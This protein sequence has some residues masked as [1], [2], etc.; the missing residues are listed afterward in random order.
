[1]S[2]CEK[3]LIRTRDSCDYRF[4]LLVIIL[5]CNVLK[6]SCEVKH[7]FSPYRTNVTMRCEKTNCGDR[8]TWQR[9]ESEVWKYRW[10]VWSVWCGVVGVAAV[11]IVVGVERDW[12]VAGPV[13]SLSH[14]RTHP[15]VC[16]IDAMR[17]ASVKCWLPDQHQPGM[18]RDTAKSE[19]EE[20]PRCV[21]VCTVDPRYFD[22]E[23]HIL[24]SGN[25]K[26]RSLSLSVTVAFISNKKPCYTR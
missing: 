8:T 14:P 13:G 12:R 26:T 23:G 24:R 3:L 9:G 16:W 25:I 17:Q 6:T 5:C 19:M 7:I 21:C 15:L 18:A 22:S 20:V 4:Q 11:V 1:M 10:P 2:L